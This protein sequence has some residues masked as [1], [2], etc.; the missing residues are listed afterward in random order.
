[1]TNPFALHH[2][3]CVADIDGAIA[4]S[5]TYERAQH[6][7]DPRTG[8]HRSQ[9]ASA[10]VTRPDLGLADTLSPALAVAGQEFLEVIEALRDYEG[11]V[12]ESD[13]CWNFT[14][15]FPFTSDSLSTTQHPMGAS[16]QRPHP[17]VHILSRGSPA[18]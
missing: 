8:Q 17:V 11:S 14:T 4:T 6:L 10:S 7:I 1:V 15:G 2:Q 12:I 3:A 13:G 5:G 18:E 9:V 16:C